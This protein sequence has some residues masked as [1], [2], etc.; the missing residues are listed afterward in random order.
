MYP[1][2]DDM[3]ASGEQRRTVLVV[4]DEVLLRMT[5]AEEL[6]A[7][8]IIVVEAASGDE[9]KNLVLAGVEFDLV[10]SDI[11][12]PGKVD[13]A[14][15][16]QWLAENDVEAPVFLTSGLPSAL[17]RARK[18]CPNAKAFITKPYEHDDVLAQIEAMLKPRN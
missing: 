18:L 5:L 8:E 12:M 4:E 7:R 14:A 17:D 16:A 11:M 9:A 15:F 6:R 1:A 2:K 13:G 10:I 3:L